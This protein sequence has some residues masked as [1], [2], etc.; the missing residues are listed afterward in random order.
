MFQK[1]YGP[2][3]RYPETKPLKSRK[4]MTKASNSLGQGYFLEGSY[5]KHWTKSQLVGHQGL[6]A[7]TWYL[8]LSRRQTS[9]FLWDLAK[10]KLSWNLQVDCYHKW[11]HVVKDWNIGQ[12]F[13]LCCLRSPIV[14]QS[15]Q[16]T[17]L[18]TSWSCAHIICLRLLMCHYVPRVHWCSCAFIFSTCKAKREITR[19]LENSL[20]A[21]LYFL[22]LKCLI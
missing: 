21:Y 20:Q 13:L 11:Q 16:T 5:R 22:Y 2:C 14:K 1:S 9:R 7:Q 6:T 10:E 19:E 8:L 17:F 12:D 4:W 15:L 18:D 3:L